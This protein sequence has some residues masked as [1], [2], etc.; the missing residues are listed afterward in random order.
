MEKNLKLNESLNILTRFALSHPKVIHKISRMANYNDEPKIYTYVAYYETGNNNN[1]NSSS[2]T[3]FNQRRALIKVLGEATE[4]YCLNFVE[5]KNLITSNISMLKAPYLDPLKI[6]SFS[7]HQLLSKSF[8]RFVFNENTKF[9]WIE[10]YSLIEK[11]RVLIPAQLVFTYYTPLPNEPC[12]RFPIS[13]GAASHT[14]FKK[15]LYT[16]ICEIVERDSFM[17]Y[18]LNRIPAPLVD[19]RSIPNKSLKR[20]LPLLDRYKLALTVFDMTTDLQI[21]VYVS[22]LLDKTGNG[23]AVSIGLK[24]GFNALNTLVGAIE[25]SLMVRTW[26]RDKFIYGSTSFKMPKTIKTIDQR[27]YFWFKP[28]T[29]AY[30]NF[31]FKSKNVKKLE[32]MNINDNEYFEKI[33]QLFKRANLDIYYVDVT[34]KE[35]KNAG[36]TVLKVFIPELFPLYFD[37]KYPYNGISRL[38]HVPV[39]LGIFKKPKTESELNRIPHP[40]L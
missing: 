28:D 31:L 39:K 18:Y 16:G 21:P 7:K 1:S 40:V 34:Q 25:E 23:P 36:F 27:A 38:Y 29:I 5:E 24:A 2:G 15:A 33:K 14:S 26:I 10:G 4:R 13:T 32:E 9:K 6:P 19:I 20:I 11:K 3:S 12:I 37:E 22:I 35:I 8:K 17:I 30:L